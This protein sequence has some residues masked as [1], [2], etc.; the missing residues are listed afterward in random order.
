[1]DHHHHHHS[2]PPA[3]T[4]THRCTVVTSTFSGAR[5]PRS[6]LG[7]PP[8]TLRDM[9]QVPQSLSSPFTNSMTYNNNFFTVVGGRRPISGKA[10]LLPGVLEKSLSLA[11]F[12]LWCMAAFLGWWPHPPLLHLHL[13]PLLHVSSLPRV[14]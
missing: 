10:V 6:D 2:R 1:M 11:S 12:S 7:F 3:P 8:Y 4:F 14:S 13:S 9:G 5:A